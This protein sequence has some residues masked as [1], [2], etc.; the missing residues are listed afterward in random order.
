[1]ADTSVLAPESVITAARL[2]TVPTQAATLSVPIR[3]TA[4]DTA[5]FTVN[6]ALFRTAQKLYTQSRATMRSSTGGVVPLG[7]ADKLSVGVNLTASMR[8]SQ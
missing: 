4:G 8:V 6:T 7:A 1:M 5:R 3:V 2:S